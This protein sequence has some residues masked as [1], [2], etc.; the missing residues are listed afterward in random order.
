MFVAVITF[1][2]TDFELDRDYKKV[3]CERIRGS[4]TPLFPILHPRGESEECM[5]FLYAQDN[6]ERER[7]RWVG[8]EEKHEERLKNEWK[9]ERQKT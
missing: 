6:E 9:Q 4:G 5:T 3:K 1:N 2:L 7:T 8:M